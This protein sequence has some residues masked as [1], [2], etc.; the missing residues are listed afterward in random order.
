MMDPQER[1][2]L[3]VCWETMENAGYIPKTLVA[4]KGKNKRRPVG[5]FAG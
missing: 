2:F 3:E 4:P 1:L 5:V